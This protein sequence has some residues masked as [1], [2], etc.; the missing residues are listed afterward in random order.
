MGFLFLQLALLRVETYA[1][2]AIA[3]CELLTVVVPLAEQIVQFP[4]QDHL[5]LHLS[6]DRNSK[7]PELKITSLSRRHISGASG[8]G[9]AMLHSLRQGLRQVLES[10]RRRFLEGARTPVG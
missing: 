9:P 4:P 3:Q 2:W 7:C 8:S 6:A 1:A 5:G 10:R